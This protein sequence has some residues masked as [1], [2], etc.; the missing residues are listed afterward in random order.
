MRFLVW[1]TST[2]IHRVEGKDTMGPNDAQIVRVF[3]REPKGSIADVTLDSHTDAEIVIDAEAGGTLHQNQG[4]Y[5][6]TLVV[7][8]LT[9]GSIIPAKVQG[10][11]KA[12]EVEG[13]FADQHWMNPAANFSFTVS[14][15]ELAKRKGHLAEAYGAVSYGSQTPGATLALS[16]PFLIQ[17]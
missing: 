16:Q 17:K 14:K 15:A 8:D 13:H 5:C 4:A 3:S 1:E 11:T 6:V 12:G 7:R 9:D 10:A 2:R